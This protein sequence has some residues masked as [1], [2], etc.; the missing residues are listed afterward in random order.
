M[1]IAGNQQWVKSS[2]IRLLHL[3]QQTNTSNNTLKFLHGIRQTSDLDLTTRA[4]NYAVTFDSR[5]FFCYLCSVSN[6]HSI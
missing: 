6:T 2:F 1:G 5:P 4:E 3:M